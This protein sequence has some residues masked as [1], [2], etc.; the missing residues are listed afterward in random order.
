MSSLRSFLPFIYTCLIQKWMWPGCTCSFLLIFSSTFWQ[1]HVTTLHAV[2]LC[3]YIN[4]SEV[5]LRAEQ[6][7]RAFFPDDSGHFN[8]HDAN[9]LFGAIHFVE[10]PNLAAISNPRLTVS[11]SAQSS[12]SGASASYNSNPAPPAFKS[13]IPKQAVPK[14]STASVKIVRA[15]MERSQTGKVDFF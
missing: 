11:S 5:W 13:V 4:N 1:L 9:L 8:L 2:W 3:S 15:K 14:G 6:D 7:N 10:G 12:G